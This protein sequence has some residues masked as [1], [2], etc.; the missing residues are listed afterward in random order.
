M[1]KATITISYDEEKLSALNM[2]LAQKGV[3]VETELERSLETMYTKTVPAGVREFIEM[4]SGNT[5]KPTPAKKLKSS[6]SSAVGADG[7]EVKPN[8]QP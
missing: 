2:Y 4:K 6:S 3:Q 7:K 1:K 5:S 8:A